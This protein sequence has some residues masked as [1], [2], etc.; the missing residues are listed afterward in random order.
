MIN[1]RTKADYDK[2]VEGLKKSV[3]LYEKFKYNNQY[4]LYLANGKNITYKISENNVPHLLGI[5]PEN[6]MSF[7]LVKKDSHFNVL[8]EFFYE[9]YSIY[10][11]IKEGKLKYTDIFSPY[12]EEKLEIFGEQIKIPF[13]NNIYFICEYDRT[14]SYTSKEIDGLKA[15]YYIA[16]KSND[17]NIILLGLVEHKPN[18]YAVQTSRVIRKDDENYS[19]KLKELLNNQV[20][21]IANT[22]KIFNYDAY[23]E[24]EYHLYIKPKIELLENLIKLS[25]STSAIPNTVKGNLFDLNG[26]S[27]KSAELKDKKELLSILKNKMSNNELIEMDDRSFETRKSIDGEISSIIDCYNDYICSSSKSNSEVGIKYSDLAN[28]NE[29]LISEK[30]N[31][32][33][34]I[35]LLEQQVGDLQQQKE[36]L[37]S[38]KEKYINFTKKVFKLVDDEKK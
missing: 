37:E 28:E 15:D 13:P 38:Y 29:K 19:L 17:D 23:E 25:E 5:L 8:K 33:S 12:I 4:T 9:S 10:K 36:E 3:K 27:I 16:R 24:K 7:G 14:R 30:T 1:I 2:I 11:K 20:I 21:T 35:L 34:K 22:L 6:L 31:L 26:V 18:C 32:E